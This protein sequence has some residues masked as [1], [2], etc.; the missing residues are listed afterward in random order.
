MHGQPQFVPFLG[1]GDFI[2]DKT[3]VFVH[4]PM[5]C[6][7]HTTL[8][9]FLSCWLAS[10]AILGLMQESTARMEYSCDLEESCGHF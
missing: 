10:D 1:P 8:I 9:G 5:S 6:V 4:V 2:L 3:Q 7:S